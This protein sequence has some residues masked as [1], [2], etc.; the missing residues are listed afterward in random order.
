M[1]NN[2]PLHNCDGTGV[3]A[4]VLRFAPG[5]ELQPERTGLETLQ[6]VDIVPTPS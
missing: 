4:K 3:G 1:A 6:L 5:R 2:D